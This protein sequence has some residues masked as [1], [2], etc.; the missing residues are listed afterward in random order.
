MNE[1]EKTHHICGECG[2]AIAPVEG[3]HYCGP[4]WETIRGESN[5]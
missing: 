3:H 5:G 2:T 1:H 4:C